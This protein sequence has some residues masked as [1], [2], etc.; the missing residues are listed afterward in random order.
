ML[1][2]F[3][4]LQRFMNIRFFD[5]WKTTQS[6]WLQL[7]RMTTYRLSKNVVGRSRV[8]IIHRPHEKCPSDSVKGCQGKLIGTPFV[9]YLKEPICGAN[10]EAGV[11]RL[12]SPLKRTRPSVKLQN[13]KEN[14]F[15]KEVIEEPSN[16]Y[17]SK[18]LSMDDAEVEEKSSEALF[19]C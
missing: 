14:G 7:R 2:R 17:N 19:L 5:I 3:F 12:L 4:C 6:Y 1:M 10:V 9:T 16:S 18:N 13:G 8:E 11:T 15:E